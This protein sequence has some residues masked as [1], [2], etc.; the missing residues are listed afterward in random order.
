M[1]TDYY[2][3]GLVLAT[4]ETGPKK[5]SDL[6]RTVFVEVPGPLFG[7]GAA[8]GMSEA[9]H[10][11]RRSAEAGTY[12]AALSGFLRWIAGRHGDLTGEA[13]EVRLEETSR[14][15]AAPHGRT[16]R[17]A[18]EVAEGWRAFLSYARDV[19]A[20]TDAEGEE[21]WGRVVTALRELAEGQGEALTDADPVTRFLALL[22]ALLRTGAVYLR[23][24]ETGEAPEEHAEA[25]GW[26]WRP[27]GNPAEGEGRWELRRPNAAPVGYLG[28]VNGEPMAFF[29][30]VLYQEVNRA[31]EGEGYA[32]PAPKT[33]WKQVR[34]R[35]KP[36]GLMVCEGDRATYPRRVYGCGPKQRISLYNICW[37]IPTERDNGTPDLKTLSHTAFSG[38]PFPFSLTGH[39]E[40]NG[41]PGLETSS[42][43]AF[44]GVPFHFSADSLEQDGPEVPEDEQ[45]ADAF[46]VFTV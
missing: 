33:L 35:L 3:R 41:T 22:S 34:D 40:R 13:L 45:D 20:V 10:A 44:S 2:P 8:P 28:T 46:E 7:E 18:A 15:F 39:L 16:P 38:V 29:E 36:A 43:T 32:L 27:F 21:V 5:L 11:A 17:N 23:D 42:S 30:A 26:R 9:Y 1:R 25:C 12:A 19:G 4:A 6:A 37:P 31:A 14:L 24:A